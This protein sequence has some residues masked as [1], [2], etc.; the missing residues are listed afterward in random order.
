MLSSHYKCCVTTDLRDHEK[1]LSCITEAEVLSN[2]RL[3]PWDYLHPKQ[4]DLSVHRGLSQ[5]FFE[6]WVAMWRGRE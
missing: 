2:G 6:D 4:K 3:S 1:T 5:M